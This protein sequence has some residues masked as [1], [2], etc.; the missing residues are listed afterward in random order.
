MSD[1]HIKGAVIEH[2]LSVAQKRLGADEY[3]NCLAA[4]S[5]HMRAAVD[6][7]HASA[8]VAEQ[9]L[10]EIIAWLLEHHGLD[11]VKAIAHDQQMAM[12]KR[13]HVF[14]SRFAGPKNLVR[15]AARVWSQFRDGGN[16]IAEMTGE[17]SARLIV[18]NRESLRPPG[19]AE[20]FWA[21]CAAAIEMS[22][23]KNVTGNVTRREDGVVLLDFAWS[24]V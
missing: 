17:H 11:V 9:L 23:A 12:A 16:A 8:W 10:V 18:T 14:F 3:E 6:S 24:I 1:E 20:S 4:L 5:P 15:I 2:Y 21:S 22:R 13:T 19:C 7:L